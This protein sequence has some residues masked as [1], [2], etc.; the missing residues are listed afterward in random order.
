MSSGGGKTT[1]T[2]NDPPKWAI[3]YFKGNLD[4]ASQYANEPYQP[5]TGQR[6]VGV[7]TMNPY[8]SNR[9]ANQQVQQLTGDITNAYKNGVQPGL[10]A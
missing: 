5:Y 4:Q 9:Y 2:T 6:V 8:T 1:T 3:D 7:D 10:M